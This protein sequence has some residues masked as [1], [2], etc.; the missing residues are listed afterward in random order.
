VD[1]A[2][3]GRARADPAAARIFLAGGTR[4]AE[5]RRLTNPDL[6]RTLERL[7][8]GRAGFYEGE[9]AREMARHAREHGGLFTEGDL[10][11]QRSKWGASISGTYR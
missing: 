6:A 2:L 1:R 8:D 10:A 11:A 4:P 3:G 7:A 9:T 5:G